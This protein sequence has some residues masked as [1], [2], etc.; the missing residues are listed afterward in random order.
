MKQFA[1]EFIERNRMIILSDEDA[2]LVIGYSPRV[3]PLARERTKAALGRARPGASVSFMELSESAFMLKAAECGVDEKKRWLKGEA[4]KID[5]RGPDI[6]SIDSLAPAITILNSLLLEARERGASDI[7]LE[8]RGGET[9]LRLRLDGV[10]AGV[11]T[12]DAD[13][14]KALAIRVKLLANLNT[15]ENRRPQDGRFS[16]RAGKDEYDIRVSS[17]P[18]AGGESVVLRFLDAADGEIILEKLGFTDSALR[19]ISC[20]PALT[21][22]LVL[23]TGPTGSGKTTTLAALANACDPLSRKIV[24]IEDPV[25]YRIPG[26]IQI[27][28]N[29][30]LDLD[31]SAILRRALRQDPDVLLIGEIRDAETAGLAVRAALTGHLVLSTLHTADA[32]E[33]ETRLADMGVPEYILHSVIKTVIA[34]RLVR[35]TGK[36]DGLSGRAP[37]TECAARNEDGRLRIVQSFEEE[38]RDRLALAITTEEEIARIFGTRRSGGAQ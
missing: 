1:G 4:K 29:E 31:F 12:F 3:D 30:A 20:V 2:A 11:R 36:T 19:E 16:I 14:G 10:L 7:H 38:I 27:Q 5:A 23:V 13:T 15:L 8:R 9:A 18:C 21:E 37:I 17:V 26:V 34:Q 25:E 6:A 28:T 32:L 35:R 24:S 33:A 22:G